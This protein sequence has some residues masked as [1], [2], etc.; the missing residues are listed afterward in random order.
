MATLI[1]IFYSGHVSPGW[2]WDR[3]G[4]VGGSAVDDLRLHFFL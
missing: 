2:R 4:T 3:H 1:Q